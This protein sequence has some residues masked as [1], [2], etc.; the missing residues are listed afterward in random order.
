MIIRT[1]GRILIV[2]IGFALAIVASLIMLVLIG[3]RELGSTYVENTDL[4]PIFS[5]V[6]D[7]WGVVLFAAALGPALTIL[8]ALAA[9]VFGEVARIR[10]VI[11]YMLAGGA[12]LLALPL[13]Y[14]TG[15]GISGALPNTRYMVIFSASGFI[16]GFVYWLIAGRKA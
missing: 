5:M 12:A 9:I 16:G 1:I 3:G 4:D 14:V 13:L 10:S 6:A 11:Y 15:D 2:T 8:P 7:V